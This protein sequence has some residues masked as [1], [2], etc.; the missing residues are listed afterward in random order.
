MAAVSVSS[1]SC[2]FVTRLTVWTLGDVGSVIT[3]ASPQFSVG[4]SYYGRTL[5]G[6]VAVNIDK[7]ASL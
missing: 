3:T 6:R 4:V 5:I 2:T 1:H 7:L